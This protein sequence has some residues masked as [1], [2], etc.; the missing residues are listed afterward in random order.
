MKKPLSIFFM[1]LLLNGC[2]VNY[3]QIFETQSTNTRKID[4]FFVY[5][6]DTVKITYSFWE[7]YG[8]LSFGVYNKLNKPIYIDW[9]NSS[10]INNSNKID[11]WIDETQKSTIDYFSSYLYRGPLLKPGFAVQSGTQFS[12]STEVK[13]ERITFIPPKSNYYKSQF[14]LLP[15]ECYKLNS[16]SI[17]TTIEPRRDRPKKNTTIYSQDFSSSNSPLIFRN[18]LAFA[19]SENSKEFFFVDNE[20]YINSVKQMDLKH[21]WGR[22][23]GFDNKGNPIYPKN[24]FKVGTSF[25]IQVPENCGNLSKNR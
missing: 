19:F 6:N 10:F 4:D 22:S 20:F 2:T 25:Y 8:L 18:F 21:Y 14:Y 7:N 17:N 16:D 5:E 11:Y 23:S 3:T 13:P 1:V 15:I 24:P 9:K 12:T